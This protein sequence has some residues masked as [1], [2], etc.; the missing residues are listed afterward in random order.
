MKTKNIILVMFIGLTLFGLC[1]AVFL[2]QMFG[3]GDLEALSTGNG[4]AQIGAF[5]G[6]ILYLAARNYEKKHAK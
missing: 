1:W 5:V 3:M 6:V 2:G 4:I